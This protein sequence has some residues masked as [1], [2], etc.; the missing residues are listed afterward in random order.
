MVNKHHTPFSKEPHS[1]FF[2]ISSYQICNNPLLQHSFLK[3]VFQNK[4]NST[5]AHAR[6]FL[7]TFPFHEIAMSL[8]KEKPNF[9]NNKKLNKNQ[10]KCF[11]SPDQT[12]MKRNFAVTEKNVLFFFPQLIRH[13][14][15]KEC[16][17]RVI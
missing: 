4:I 9:L 3:C 12:L 5:H 16:H 1:F 8:H 17:Y 6:H 2:L 7:L 14:K 13:I 11:Y 15:T 10:Q